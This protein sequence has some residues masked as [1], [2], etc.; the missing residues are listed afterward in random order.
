M[1]KSQGSNRESF[2]EILSPCERSRPCLSQLG[3]W[4]NKQRFPVQDGDHSGDDPHLVPGF[5]RQRSGVFPERFRRMSV[6]LVSRA[7]HPIWTEQPRCGAFV[8]LNSWYNF[9]VTLPSISLELCAMYSSVI[10]GADRFC[11]WLFLAYSCVSLNTA[12]N[13]RLFLNAAI[14]GKRLNGGED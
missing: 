4:Q 13:F 5:V 11:D 8:L 7:Y 2:F 9:I 6:R 3:C 10:P 12:A 14:F 1:E